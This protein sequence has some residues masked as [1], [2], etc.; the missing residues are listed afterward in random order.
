MALLENCAGELRIPPCTRTESCM[1]LHPPPGGRSSRC[2][3]EPPALA[4]P[5]APPAS[6]PRWPPRAPSGRSTSAGTCQRTAPKVTTKPL[7]ARLRVYSKALS[8][9]SVSCS[10]QTVQSVVKLS[11]FKVCHSARKPSKVSSTLPEAETSHPTPKSPP[12]DHPKRPKALA[13]Q[14]SPAGHILPTRTPLLK[15]R[16]HHDP[17]AQTN[18]PTFP[19]RTEKSDAPGIGTHAAAKTGCAPALARRLGIPDAPVGPAARVRVEHLHVLALGQRHHLGVGHAK[20]RRGGP[21]MERR[22]VRSTTRK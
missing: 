13:S 4:P 8:V 17:C 7:R 6:S 21:A 22:C 16:E 5:P 1:L 11:P 20:A 2:C 9:Q 19:V 15:P 18:F 10:P 12:S 14:D 3:S